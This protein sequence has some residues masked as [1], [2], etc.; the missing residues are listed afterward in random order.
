MSKRQRSAK[1]SKK[2]KRKKARDAE[3]RAA[4]TAPGASALRVL[5]HQRS[6]GLAASVSVVG[7]A[8]VGTRES[9]V[10]AMV[11]VL[12]LLGLMW[13]VHRYGRLGTERG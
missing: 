13:S 8:L 5:Q 1:T 6:V 3:P 9:R 11:V 12:G 2:G 10:G 4:G 7:L